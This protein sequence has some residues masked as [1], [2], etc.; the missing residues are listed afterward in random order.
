M[1]IKTKSL[2]SYNGNKSPKYIIRKT[3]AKHKRSQCKLEMKLGQW[4]QCIVG[5]N[6]CLR[7]K[8][9]GHIIR[10]YSTEDVKYYDSEPRE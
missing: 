3:L 6:P 7:N 8:I 5:R 9:P 10:K 1:H 2:R 4:K